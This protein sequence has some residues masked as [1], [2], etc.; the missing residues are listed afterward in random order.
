MFPNAGLYDYTFK[1][2]ILL[3]C[4]FQLKLVN[5]FVQQVYSNRNLEIYMYENGI[6]M[7]R[8]VSRKNALLAYVVKYFIGNFRG[9]L[10]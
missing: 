9:Y 3:E 1:K 5:I 6:A 10:D 4:K 7:P 8:N 2:S